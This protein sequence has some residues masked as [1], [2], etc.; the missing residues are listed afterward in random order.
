MKKLKGYHEKSPKQAESWTCGMHSLRNAMIAKC[1]MRGFKEDISISRIMDIWNKPRQG[2]LRPL[3]NSIKVFENQDINGFSVQTIHSGEEKNIEKYVENLV[4]PVI[5]FGFAGRGSKGK[6]MTYTKKKG[7]KRFHT[8]CVVDC[9]NGNLLL[10]DSAYGN[11]SWIL[12][13]DREIIDEVAYF[14]VEPFKPELTHPLEEVFVTQKFGEDKAYYRQFGGDW[15]NGHQGLD[16][17]TRTKEWPNGIGTH[18][19][20]SHAGKIVKQ[21]NDP[22]GYGKWIELKGE[23]FTTRYCHLN[24]FVFNTGE[25]VKQD[26]VIGTSG[27]TGNIKGVHLHYEVFVDGKRVDPNKYLPKV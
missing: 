11:Y 12:K 15:V 17:R 13:E 19:R 23:K 24:D 2:F 18:I 3:V 14:N 1:K 8:A 4:T 7:R 9:V 22:K 6:L 25:D 5:V 21:G 20:A 27:D 16:L 10:N 26:T